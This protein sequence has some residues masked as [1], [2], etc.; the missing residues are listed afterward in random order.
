MAEEREVSNLRCRD[1]KY[2]LVTADQRMTK[3]RCKR[4]DHKKI[5]FAVPW[6]KFYDCDFGTICS[7]F[8]PNKHFPAI[9]QEWEELGGF[10]NWWPLWVKQ[11]LP[12]Q[13]TD[14]LVYFVLNDNEDVRYG[15]RLL[16]YVYGNLFREDGKFN[17][18]EK[19]YY[20]RHKKSEKH[21]TGY[22]LVHEEIDGVEI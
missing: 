2:Y 11:W 18:V 22:E 16:D 3:S 7:D 21:P 5:K 1:C 9:K 6:F 20:V 4:L 15:V 14:K 17:A 19:E 13:N 12:Y 10:E 8:K